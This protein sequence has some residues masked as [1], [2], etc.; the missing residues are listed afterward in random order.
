VSESDDGEQDDT[1]TDREAILARRR[2]FVVAAL[3]GITTSTLATACPCL[4]ID[5]G[6]PPE[7]DSDGQPKDDGDSVEEA[8]PEEGGAERSGGEGG[9][10]GDAEPSAGEAD[11]KEAGAD[12][13]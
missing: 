10:G 11:T 7:P 13:S 1:R 3:T 2:R 9:D 4:K 12:G 6:P 5:T 8:S